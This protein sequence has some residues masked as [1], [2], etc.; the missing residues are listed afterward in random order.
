MPRALALALALV[1]LVFVPAPVGASG[2]TPVAATA[3]VVGDHYVRE[4]HEAG[5]NPFGVNRYAFESAYVALWE[6]TNGVA[7]LQTTPAQACGASPDLRHV[8]A[9][10]RVWAFP[11]FFDAGATACAESAYADP[12]ILRTDC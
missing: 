11:A 4:A 5:A 1:P 8:E 2:C 12:P 9:G 3:H 10:E 7:G 6:E